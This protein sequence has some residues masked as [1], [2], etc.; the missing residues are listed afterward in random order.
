MTISKLEIAGVLLNNKIY[1]IGGFGNGHSTSTVEVHDP[2]SDILSSVASLLQS[3]DHATTASYNGKLYV[4]GGGYLDRNLQTIHLWSTSDRWT[5]EANLTEDRSAL[6]ANF[7]NG[8]L[9]GGVNNSTETLTSTLAYDPS[10]K[11]IEKSM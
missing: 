5:Q 2:L 8:T 7:I 10:N 4:V 1:I 11:W 6:T 9:V 3:L